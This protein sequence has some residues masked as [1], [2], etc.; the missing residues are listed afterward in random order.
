MGKNRY[1]NFT[2]GLSP[3]SLLEAY[4]MPEC[5]G[6]SLT[7]LLS[8]TSRTQT[9]LWRSEL[10]NISLYGHSDIIWTHQSSQSQPLD[11][12]ED[13]PHFS[14]LLDFKWEKMISKISQKRV[15]IT[16]GE[17]VDSFGKTPGSRALVYIVLSFGRE[18][19]WLLWA[20]KLRPYKNTHERHNQH[21]AYSPMW[22]P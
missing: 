10:D 13:L 21:S 16:P 5:N 2:L 7:V 3:G 9:V 4:E 14:Q 22:S 20:D 18:R 19:Y 11:G 8:L 12:V 6:I 15:T 17:I 1:Q